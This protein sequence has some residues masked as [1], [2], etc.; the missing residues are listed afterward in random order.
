[1]AGT[2]KGLPRACDI[3]QRGRRAGRPG[4]TRAGPSQRDGLA[5]AEQ[6]IATTINAPHGDESPRR[7]EAQMCADT[8]GDGLLPKSRFHL[9]A[10][11]TEILHS[12]MCL[13]RLLEER[14]FD[15]DGVRM[16]R[17]RY[18]GVVVLNDFARR[19]PLRV[20]GR[21][22]EGTPLGEPDPVSVSGALDR[23]L[24]GRRARIRR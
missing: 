6:T 17:D 15:I 12:G 5:A 7:R 13:V 14:D 11:T 1:M 4:I 10:S 19:P 3:Q 21:H 23:E 2:G 16:V 24:R 9:S 8:D 22:G 20:L 18:P